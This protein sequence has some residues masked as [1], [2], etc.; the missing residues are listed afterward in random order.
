M[1]TVSYVAPLV[2]KNKG[3]LYAYYKQLE[4][5]FVACRGC[6]LNLSGLDAASQ[7]QRLKLIQHTCQVASSLLTQNTAALNVYQAPLTK[8]TP[9][10]VNGSVYE[11]PPGVNWNQMSDRSHPHTQPNLSARG[12][13]YGT[14]GPTQLSTFR[15]KRTTTALRP[16]ALTPRGSGVDIKHN[17]YA[18]YLARIKGRGPLRAGPLPPNYGKPY[19]PFNRAAPI[20]GG[21]TTKTALTYHCTC[22][23]G[24]LLPP[25]STPVFSNITSV[26]YQYTI[27][28]VVWVLSTPQIGYLPSVVSMFGPSLTHTLGNTS[29]SVGST[30]IYNKGTITGISAIGVYTVLMNNTQKQITANT[31]QLMPYFPCACPC[32]PESSLPVSYL[33]SD[34]GLSYSCTLASYTTAGPVI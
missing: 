28:Q 9:I 5:P 27:G 18:R 3:N 19:I 1:V 34:T 25:P 22:V 31:S 30:L 32:P 14:N 33:D 7:Y 8:Y 26:S 11:A 13:I 21:K 23:P 24:E 10:D 6:N 4:Q 29:R 20:Y 17:S 16:G 15:G 12:S 2:I